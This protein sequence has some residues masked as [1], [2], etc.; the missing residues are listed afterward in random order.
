[1]TYNIHAG[2]GWDIRA[3]SAVRPRQIDPIADVIRSAA[4]DI[5]ALQEVDVLAD[6]AHELAARLGMELRAVASITGGTRRDYGIATLTRLPIAS[7]REVR[8]P[9]QGHPGF[10]CALVTE[11]A[12]EGGALDMI[13]V[14]VSM[15]YRDRPA[16]AAALASAITR[17]PIVVAGD[18]NMTPLSP[19]F[20]LLARGLASATTLARTWPAPLPVAPIDHVL[21]RGLVWKS[22][23]AWTGGGARRASDHLPVVA[24]FELA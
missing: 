9:Q 17:S 4:P 8:M 13:N 12:W 14:H 18:F 24:D 7:T 3:R 11:L 16:Q 2:R 6:Q 15:M 10:R 5:V 20:R 23:R 1:M 22:G 21:F 19:A